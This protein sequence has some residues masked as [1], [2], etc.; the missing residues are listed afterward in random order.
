MA[1]FDAVV[2]A[3]DAVVVAFDAVVVVVAVAVAVGVRS[4]LATWKILQ[5]CQNF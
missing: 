1:A 5:S 2:V 3:F 4:L